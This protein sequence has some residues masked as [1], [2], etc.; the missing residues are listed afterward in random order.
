MT[1]P[2]SE[3]HAMTSSERAY[4]VWERIEDMHA[5]NNDWKRVLQDKW[6]LVT[7]TGGN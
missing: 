1:S 3:L 5:S 4:R 2:I 7:H 6:E